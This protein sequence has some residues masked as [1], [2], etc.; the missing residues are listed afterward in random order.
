MFILQQVHNCIQN[1]QYFN[2]LVTTNIDKFLI[3]VIVKNNP[4][5]EPHGVR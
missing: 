4:P 5:E 3:L 1:R 2:F